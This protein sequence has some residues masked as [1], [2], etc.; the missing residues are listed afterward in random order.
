MLAPTEKEILERLIDAHGLDDVVMSLGHIC[1]EKAEHIAISY[2]DKPLARKWERAGKH[3]T[4]A[5]NKC[6]VG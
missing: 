4:N 2:N 6:D 1:I 5:L 3:I